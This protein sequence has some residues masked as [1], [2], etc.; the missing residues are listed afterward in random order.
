MKKLKHIMLLMF[1]CTIYLDAFAQ[2]NL[3]EQYENSYNSEKKKNENSAQKNS[4]LKELDIIEPNISIENEIL[5]NNL[6]RISKQFEKL[7]NTQHRELSKNDESVQILDFALETLQNLACLK[8]K[9]G[10][11]NPDNLKELNIKCT[12]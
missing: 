3:I 6:V 1:F 9:I 11:F 5:K 10:E 7:K 12:D 8:M 4:E 2:I